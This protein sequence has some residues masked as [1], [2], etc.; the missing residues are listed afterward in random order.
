M[1][2]EVIAVG[3]ELL[4]G[5]IVDTNSSYIGE[6]LALSGIDCTFQTK[7][8]DNLERIVLALRTALA[9]TDAVLVCG[10]LGPT[11]D[12]ITREA[13]ALVMNVELR[14]D[15]ELLEGIRAMFSSRGR[16]MAS[17]N[18]RQADV[19]AGASV[20]PQRIGTAPGLICPIGRKVVYA[21]PGVPYEMHEMMERAVLPDL[22][23]RD[24]DPAVI[25]SRTLR[26]WG[27][28]ESTVAELLQPRIDALSEGGPGIPTIAF[29]ASGIEGIKVRLTVK[30]STMEVAAKALA[31]EEALV[32]DVLGDVVFGT[33]DDT[34]EAAVGRLLQQR[35]WTLGLAESLTGGLVASRVVSV[36]GASEWFGGGIVSYA[37]SVKE[38]LLMVPHGPV[39]SL[40]AAAAMAEGVRA[41]LG[42]DVGLSTTGV[43]GPGQQEGHRAGTVFVGI[44]L[45]G[46]PA[47]AVELWLP[48]DRERVRQMTVISA[49]NA[50][51]SRLS[52]RP[53]EPSCAVPAASPKEQDPSPQA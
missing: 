37:A 40:E 21:M 27:L 4:L 52:A 30:A 14:R 23:S 17:N 9:R 39:I 43:A 51:R 8:G 19:P 50:L 18:A 33:D 2:A 44:C 32:R 49:L 6:Q 36:P 5:Q 13:I 11:Q 20:I 24:G 28:A 53:P 15:E 48:G 46:A 7:V 35:Q 34:M 29:L 25:A 31:T 47:E 10:G 12:D 26:T 42:T 45:P 3:T 1:R 38:S 22:R 41:A 16:V